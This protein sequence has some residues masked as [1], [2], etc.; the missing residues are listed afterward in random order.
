MGDDNSTLTTLTDMVIKA[1]DPN[2]AVNLGLV[3]GHK[4]QLRRFAAILHFTFK[5][6]VTTTSYS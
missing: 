2:A 5:N 1:I 6:N 3:N 4:I